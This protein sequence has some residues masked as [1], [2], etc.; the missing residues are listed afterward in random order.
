M[1]FRIILERLC[2]WYVFLFL[3][4]YGFGK[5]MGQ[6]FYRPGKLP[7]EVANTLLGEAGGFELAW[8][9]MG[10]SQAYILFIG[11]SQLIGAWCLLWN[12]T[13]LLGVII[14]LPIMV[15]I[16]VFDLN[17]LDAY[18]ALAGAII[19]FSM[20]LAIMW[21]HRD[22]VLAV[23]QIITRLSPQEPQPLKQRLISILL[24]LLLMALVFGIDQ[25]VVN[26]LGH[27]KG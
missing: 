7:P 3:S 2:R 11:I 13:K 5:I 9:F 1:D 27:G 17:F 23:F 19:Y 4:V 26:W 20:L 25:T 24:T 6:Q 16:I 21:F 22:R 10:H 18:G 15:N 14:L 12:R 8:T